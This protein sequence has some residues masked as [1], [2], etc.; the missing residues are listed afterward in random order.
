MPSFGMLRR[1]DLVRTDVSEEFSASIIRGLE[2][3][4]GTTLEITGNQ[5]FLIVVGLEWHP[6]S[7]MRINAKVR[8]KIRQPAAVVSQHS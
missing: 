1:V 7:L 4:V 3:E 5:I 6:L 8:I 2:C